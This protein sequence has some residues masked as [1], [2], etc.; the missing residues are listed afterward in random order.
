[1]ASV[2][3][4]FPTVPD[5]PAKSSDLLTALGRLVIAWSAS[6]FYFMLLLSRLMA[7]PDLSTD[8]KRQK[9]IFEGSAAAIVDFDAISAIYFSVESSR[10]R[11]DL[12]KA[13]AKAR[14]DAGRMGDD[15]YQAV[16]RIL[17]RHRR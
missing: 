7:I 17:N 5:K 10:G 2:S 12:A 16:D 15:Q 1:V 6:E 3:L 14:Q 11:R 4:K 8:E 9:A 13:V